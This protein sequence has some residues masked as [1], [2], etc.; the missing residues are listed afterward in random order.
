[1]CTAPNYL[2]KAKQKMRYKKKVAVLVTDK[3]SMKKPAA[4]IRAWINDH[5]C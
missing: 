1:M 4:K 3:V 2:I 5:H